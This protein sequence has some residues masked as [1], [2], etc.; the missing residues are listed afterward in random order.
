MALFLFFLLYFFLTSYWHVPSQLIIK[1]NLQSGTGAVFMWD[2]GEGYNDVESANVM[3]GNYVSTDKQGHVIKIRRTGK[4]NPTA[5]LSEVR[6]RRILVD[7]TALDLGDFRSQKDIEVV[8]KRHLFM[9][10]DGAAIVFTVKKAKKIEV[11]FSMNRTRGYVEIEINGDAREYDLYAPKQRLKTIFRTTDKF[12]PGDFTAVINLPRYDVKRFK[13]ETFEACNKII[14]YSAVIASKNGNLNLPIEKSYYISEIQFENIKRNTKKYF[15]PIRFGFQLIFS[16][17]CAY[18][19]IFIFNFIKIRGGLKRIFF[20]SKRYVFWLMFSGAVLSFSTWLLAYWPGYLTSDSIHIWWA[21][22]KPG[23]FIHSHPFMNVIYYR[24]LQ[25]IWDNVAIVGI[26]QILLTSLLGSYIFYYIYKNGVSIFLILPFY[27]AFVLSIPIGLYNISLWKDIPFA[28][29]VL[30]SAFYLMKMYLDKK[31]SVL[32]ISYKEIM[33]LLLL[34]IGLC[35][36]R[37]NGIV[38]IIIIPIVLAVSKIISIKRVLAF[39]GVLLIIG[40]TNIGIMKLYD[41]TDFLFDR[42]NFFIK[43]LKNES[44]SKTALRVVKQYPTVLD[45]NTYKRYRIWYDIWYRND[46][47]IRWHHNFTR[48]TGYNEFIQYQKVYP[49]SVKLYKYLDSITRGSYREPWVYF[50]WNP[51]YMLY[52]IPVFFLYRYFPL[53]AVFG[54]VIFSQVFVL[55]WVLG[56]YNYNWRYYYFLLFSIY[57]LIPIA[58]L[59]IKTKQF[60]LP[61]SQRQREEDVSPSSSCP[62]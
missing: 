50:T 49:I 12:I 51:Y 35:L 42:A 19:T 58:A 52:I 37:Y 54:S 56:P 61:F 62:L 1:G 28:I 18:I 5:S 4:K 26:F 15:H 30:F 17:I 22:K 39:F 20:S 8:H 13:L 53:T 44:I 3:L 11:I 10:K 14:L 59:D 25:Q 38:Y 36:F 9:K 40:I 43:R 27:F 16:A 48:K 31:R 34:I 33:I 41:K 46:G 7:G 45:I 2:S 24:F 32:K 23:Y 47:F 55:L 21:A 29:L 6:I 57:F 60:R